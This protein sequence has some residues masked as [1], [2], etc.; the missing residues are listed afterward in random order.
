MA[1]AGNR[2]G[3]PEQPVAPQT[4]ENA[5]ARDGGHNVGTRFGQPRP[6]STRQVEERESPSEVGAQKELESPLERPAGDGRE[7]PPGGETPGDGD[8]EG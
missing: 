3:K 8:D 5:A 7:Q 4:Q 1:K 6:R 2:A